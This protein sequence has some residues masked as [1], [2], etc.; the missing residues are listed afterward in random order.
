MWAFALAP[1]CDLRPTTY[2]SPYPTYD[3]PPTT[4]HSL[5]LAC[6]QELPAAAA[7]EKS[8]MFFR[9]SRLARERFKVG[10]LQECLD[11]SCLLCE[12]YQFVV[13]VNMQA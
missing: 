12:L 11:K 1:T 5:F 6:N 7:F 9:Y 4:Y 2:H 13:F 8:Q 3:L 10:V